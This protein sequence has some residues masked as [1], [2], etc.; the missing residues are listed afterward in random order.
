MKNIQNL[1]QKKKNLLN[2]IYIKYFM[3]TAGNDN[4]K[5]KIEQDELIK[6]LEKLAL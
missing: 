3:Q 6:Q 1:K 2:Q 5:I 4:P